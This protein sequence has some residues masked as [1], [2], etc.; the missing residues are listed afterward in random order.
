MRSEEILIVRSVSTALLLY[1]RVPNTSSTSIYQIQ[2]QRKDGV[3]VPKSTSRVPSRD[4]KRHICT[5]F[6]LRAFVLAETFR[7]T[8]YSLS[9]SPRAMFP[10]SVAPL[11]SFELLYIAVS[12]WL[13]KSNGVAA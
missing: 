6:S 11:V 12:E 3:S 4:R 10:F 1:W 5:L 2:D 8:E 9:V 7:G 13:L